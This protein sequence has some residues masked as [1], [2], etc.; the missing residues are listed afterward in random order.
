MKK[1][2]ISAIVVGMAIVL[3]GCGHNPAAAQIVPAFDFRPLTA[4]YS[5]DAIGIHVF[6][7]DDKTGKIHTLAGDEESGN[8]AAWFDGVETEKFDGIETEEGLLFAVSATD[9]NNGDGAVYI[10]LIAENAKLVK[11]LLPPTEDMVG[12][13]NYLLFQNTK[14]GWVLYIEPTFGGEPVTIPI[15]QII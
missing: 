8:F 10:F 14:D 7:R 15:N 11:K 2:C 5:V 3:S 1:V 9:E 6:I 4:H 13:G 12:Y